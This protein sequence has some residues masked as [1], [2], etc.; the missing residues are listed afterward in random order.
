MSRD[1]SGNWDIYRQWKW[2]NFER[3]GNGFTIGLLGFHPPLFQS[4]LRMYPPLGFTDPVDW[5]LLRG[6][7]RDERGK[8]S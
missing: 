3:L 4:G 6:K 2:V 7:G 1:L 8:V 5:L